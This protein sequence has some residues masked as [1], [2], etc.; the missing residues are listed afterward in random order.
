MHFG[1]KSYHCP[2]SSPS[3]KR[4]CTVGAE[5]VEATL[6]YPVV[7]SGF[8]PLLISS[9]AEESSKDKSNEKGWQQPNVHWRTVERPQ[10]ALPSPPALWQISGTPAPA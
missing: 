10:P 6:T 8:A 1:S 5:V 4:G 9:E 2:Q 3:M 7:G